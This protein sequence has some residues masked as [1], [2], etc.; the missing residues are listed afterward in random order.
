VE[1]TL[2]ALETPAVWSRKARFF[3]LQLF[4]EKVKMRYKTQKDDLLRRKKTG[5]MFVANSDQYTHRFMDAEDHEMAAHG[6]GEYAGSYGGAINV[7][8][9]L[10]GRS[11]RL[12]LPICRDYDN[13]TALA[14]GEEEEVA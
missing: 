5:E 3:S 13:L 14:E 8:S 12:R 6:M 1:R 2:L 10:N 9:T 7:T 4:Q 11:S